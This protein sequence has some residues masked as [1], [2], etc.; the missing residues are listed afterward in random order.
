MSLKIDEIEDQTG[1][2]KRKVYSVTNLECLG[3][4]MGKLEQLSLD[5]TY[6]R[7]RMR[8]SFFRKSLRW[9]A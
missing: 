8:T 5:L 6:E 1:I 9:E 7:E 2:C 4:T 3:N